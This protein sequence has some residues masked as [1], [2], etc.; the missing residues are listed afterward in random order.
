MHANFFGERF[1]TTKVTN[2]D[3]CTIFAKIGSAVPLT[4]SKL[5][6]VSAQTRHTEMLRD[7]DRRTATRIRSAGGLTAGKSLVAPASLQQTHFTDEQFTEVLRWRLGC[8]QPELQARCQNFA[9]STGECC[10][11]QLDAHGDHAVICSYGPLRIKKHDQY[12]D[13]VAEILCETDAHVRREVWVK[14]FRT[15]A[16]DAWLDVWAFGGMTIQDVLID[17][18]IR[19]P[20]AT[21][22]QPSASQEDGAAA[23][24]AEAA[25]V[26]R[27]PTSG[28]RSVTPFAV[29][30]WGR[31]GETAEHALE[32]FAAE[33]TRHKRLR[34][35]DASAASFLRRWRACLDAVLSKGIA[36][37][38]NAARHGLPGRPVQR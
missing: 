11:E 23:R 9:A 28:G 8:T 33:A 24:N 3:F 2:T 5:L 12:A 31:L 37:S 34:G 16:A 13:Y 21:A 26:E 22:Y 29:E 10:N 25:K 27:Y 17:V 7:A 18:T 19:H 32:E 14:E 20:M 15:P 35:F 36:R 1:I 4:L 38:L 6:R 30:T